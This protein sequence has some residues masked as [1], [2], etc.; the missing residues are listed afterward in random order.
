MKVLYFDCF[1]GI[2]G[3]MTLGALLDLGVDTDKFLNELH[4]LDVEFRIDIKKSLKKSIYGTDVDVLYDS[5]KAQVRHIKDIT[6]IIEKSTLNDNVKNNSLK[7]FRKLAAAESKIHHISEEDVHFHE[8]GAVDTI[9]DIVGSAVCMDILKPDLVMSSAVNVGSGTVKCAHGILPVPAPATCEILKGIPIYSS[10]IIGELTTPTGAAII[11][12][13]TDEYG[14]MPHLCID[15]VGYGFGKKDYGN[16]NCLRVCYGS[17]E[18][19]LSKDKVCVLETNVDDMSAE[20]SGYLMDKLLKSG[21]LDVY[22]TPIYMKKDRPA[23][24]VSVICNTSDSEKMQDIIFKETT[25]FGVR[26]INVERSIL[27]RKFEI[28][29]TC[30][31]KVSVKLSADTKYQRIKPEY[32]DCIKIAKATGVSLNEIYHEVVE[33]A[34]NIQ[35]RNNANE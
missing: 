15:G 1:S 18:N 12:N 25:T 20:V 2:S 33:K 35:E 34:K 14:A 28:V 7:M 29:D 30:Y 19:E 6:A 3:D 22:F 31:G 32:E 5:E 16:V 17:V 21:A 27:P 9:V 24:K 10:G 11:T 8:I 23:V 4:K 13:Y 26:K